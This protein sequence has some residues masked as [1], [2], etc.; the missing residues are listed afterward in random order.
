MLRPVRD[1]F[2]IPHV[3]QNP[4]NV[5]TLQAGRRFV[6]AEWAEGPG[7]GRGPNGRRAGPER[8]QVAWR[9]ALASA[10]TRGAGRQRGLSGWRS[11]EPLR[12]R[13]PGLRCAGGWW[14]F[15]PG[16]SLFFQS[17]K[18]S[19]LQQAKDGGEGD[20]VR[21]VSVPTRASRGFLP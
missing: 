11:S 10:S 3:L 21:A 15:F 4:T 1:F 7:G 8:L 16:S 17:V 12:P 18:E 13:R 2:Q 9:Q 14:W 5:G 6:T 19:I 20:R